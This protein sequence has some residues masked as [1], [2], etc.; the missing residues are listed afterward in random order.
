MITPPSTIF[1]YI[2]RQFLINFFLLMVVLLGVILMF[3][4]IELLRRAANQQHVPISSVLSMALLKLPQLGQ[5]ILP[6]G[7][8]FTAIYTCWKLNKNS[9]LVAIRS[10]GLSAWQFLN[11]LILCALLIGIFSTA[12]INPISSVFLSKYKTNISVLL[13]RDYRGAVAYS[14]LLTQ[15]AFKE[16]QY[17]R[18]RFRSRAARRD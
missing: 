16:F 9:E 1:R 5:T 2:S 7:V 8:L 18:P 6:M 17:L 14:D 13:R 10:F 15:F 11:P 4:V 3:D 12:V